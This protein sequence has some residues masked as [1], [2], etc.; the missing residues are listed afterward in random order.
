MARFA[1]RVDVPT[2]DF[3]SK[4]CAYVKKSFDG[5]IVAYETASSGEN[6]HVHCILERDGKT[7]KAVRS[8]F[9]REF[10][11]SVGNKSYSLKPCDDD[12]QAYIR[13]ICKGVDKDTPPVIWCHNGLLYTPEAI[14]DAHAKFYVNRAAIIEDR[15]RK[16]AVEKLRPV[17]LLE[18]ECKK[19]GVKGFDREGI[20]R[21]Y[22]RLWRDARKPINVFAARA[23]VNTVSQLLDGCSDDDLVR[24]ICEL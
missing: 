1:L 22:I 17:E 19:H 11:E 18:K 13:Y 24:K 3:K 10:P 14:A 23:V 7:L 21:I 15:A 4:F 12:F 6:N 8:A 16:A 9:C 20:A 5:Y 2:E